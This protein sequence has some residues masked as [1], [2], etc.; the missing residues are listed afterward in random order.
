MAG[1]S[2]LCWNGYAP[3][4][5]DSIAMTASTGSTSPT[6]LVPRKVQFD[7]SDVPL[8]WIP[9]QAFVSH[10]LS[11]LHMM[12]PTV[13]FWFCKLFNQAL[14][15]IQDERLAEDV[16]AFIRQEA[17]HARAHQGAAAQHLGAHGIE[18]QSHIDRITWIFHQGP[19]SD[20]PY[21]RPLPKWLARQWLVFRIGIIANIEHTTCFLG[22]YI[23]RNKRWD[24][25]G[26]DPTVM[27][28][29][30]WHC[31]EEVEHRCVAYDL[32][33]H[34]G[35]GYA[36]RLAA[37]LVWIPSFLTY[38]A[39]GTGHIIRQDPAF[40]GRKTG[41]LSPWYWR[42]WQRAAKGGFLPEISW[43]FKEE[44]RYLKP[45]YEPVD[46][47]DSGEALAY[48]AKSQGVVPPALS[49]GKQAPGFIPRGLE[50]KG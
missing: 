4:L 7:W 11:Q 13:E 49:G 38:Y 12:L 43:F 36:G 30:R 50:L 5:P 29:L 45:G 15:L 19:F 46:E 14:P 37:K 39:I 41:P 21:G 40:K 9:E 22:Q 27:D 32:Y 8:H 25:V 34:L 24:Q 10:Y 20:E 18:T 35:G 31:A 23:L 47:A 26:A 16:K 2:I 48:L 28:I 6:H 1:L 3:S 44:L 17:M 42:Q 33:R